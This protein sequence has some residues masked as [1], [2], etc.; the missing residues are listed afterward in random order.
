MLRGA[1]VVGT[2]FRQGGLMAALRTVCLACAFRDVEGQPTGDAP[3]C[4]RCNEPLS[5][6]VVA[7]RSLG[8]HAAAARIFQRVRK[9][10]AIACLRSQIPNITAEQFSRW[11]TATWQLTRCFRR[12]KVDRLDFIVTEW[13]DIKQVCSF[14]TIAK[15]T[16]EP[17]QGIHNIRA[18]DTA[19]L[20]IV[21]PPMILSH[22]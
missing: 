20:G 19:E 7:T 12:N 16:K 14:S 22:R 3:A 10:R 4:S 11:A 6:P 8:L 5:G 15:A 17:T 2:V 1:N 18:T 13:S 21:I 9:P